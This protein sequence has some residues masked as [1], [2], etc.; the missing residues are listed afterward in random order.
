MS[1]SVDV[2]AR[3]KI[4]EMQG[5]LSAVES[6]VSSIKTDVHEIRE[7]V[8]KLLTINQ[9]EVA[10]LGPKVEANARRIGEIYPKVEITERQQREM[11]DAQRK[12]AEEEAE[13]TRARMA[14]QT[15][16]LGIVLGIVQVLGI[17]I[18]TQFGGCEPVDLPSISGATQHEHQGRDEAEPE[19]EPE[20]HV[21]QLVGFTPFG[22][23]ITR[24]QIDARGPRPP[25]ERDTAGQYVLD[26]IEPLAPHG[27]RLGTHGE[28]ER[29]RQVPTIGQHRSMPDE[30]AHRRR[31]RQEAPA[32][33]PLEVG[34]RRAP[35]VAL[36]PPGLRDAR[37][38]ERPR[39]IG[40]RA[41]VALNLAQY[42]S[43]RLLRQRPVGGTRAPRRLP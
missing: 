30:H 13:T 2:Y 42:L 6:D 31:V 7:G 35:R 36:L 11:Q 23:P 8:G 21:R 14:E 17:A 34:Q 26:K 5:R 28:T 38:Q 43:A 24:G 22:I 18:L 33:A 29:Q 16:R 15:K 20:H 41:P 12:T 9:Y 1:E 27:L 10:P 40:P 3:E 32:A 19:P 37:P 4:G 25:V 39:R